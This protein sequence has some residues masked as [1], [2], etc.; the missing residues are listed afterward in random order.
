[1]SDDLSRALGRPLWMIS[2]RIPGEASSRRPEKVS[3]IRGD[4]VTARARVDQAA[5][6][7]GASTHLR[8]TT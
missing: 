7:I 1:M 8:T 2:W 4:C 3:W 6:S 5:R